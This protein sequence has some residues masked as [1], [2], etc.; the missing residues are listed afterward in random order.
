MPRE[1]E[2]NNGRI[3]VGT[4]SKDGALVIPSA[5]RK[6]LRIEAYDAFI[7]NVVSNANGE[8]TISGKKLG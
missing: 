6:E 2:T 8:W 5:L 7:M 3:V 4:A 1:T